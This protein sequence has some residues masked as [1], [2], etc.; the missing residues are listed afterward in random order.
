MEN[1]KQLD[2][3]DRKSLSETISTLTVSITGLRAGK[4]VLN[5]YM[6]E[7]R[8]SVLQI[9]DAQPQVKSAPVIHARWEHLG[10]DE[11]CCTAC[12]NVITTEG[13]WEKPTKKYCDECGAKMDGGNEDG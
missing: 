4:G 1:E 13:S 12:G 10:G 11:W 3:I 9:I 2:L 8:K 5:E 6:K 7:Y